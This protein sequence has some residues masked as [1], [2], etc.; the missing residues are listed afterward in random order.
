MKSSKKSLHAR[1]YRF[2]YYSDLPNN[3]CPYFWKLVLAFI[4]FSFIIY[5]SLYIGCCVLFVN[6]HL[7]KMILNC[8]SYNYNHAI[9]AVFVDICIA[10]VFIGLYI[11]NFIENN[12]KKE[13]A[14]TNQNIIKEFIK[15]K[16]NNYCPKIDWE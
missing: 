8:Y 11:N 7:V 12:Y 13:K 15:A 14:K 4:L 10:L 2:M 5:I 6:Y 1:L 9:G 16:Y 3:L